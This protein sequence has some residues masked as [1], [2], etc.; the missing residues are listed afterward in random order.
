MAAPSISDLI[1]QI[2][3]GELVLPEFKG[4]YLEIG[5]GQELRSFALPQIPNRPLSHLEDLRSTAVARK[6]TTHRKLILSLDP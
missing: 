1:K 4:L 6:V 5:T 3:F 2:K